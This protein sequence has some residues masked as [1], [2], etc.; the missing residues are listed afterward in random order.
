MV[1]HVERGG[2]VVQS[3]RGHRGRSWKGRRGAPARGGARGGDGWAEGWS[4]GVVL[5]GP[6]CGGRRWHDARRS[7]DWV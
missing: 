7:R 1:A 6:G 4:E 3:R 5:S 2:A